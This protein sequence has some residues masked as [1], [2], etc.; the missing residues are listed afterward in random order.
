M[1]NSTGDV[2]AYVMGV[3]PYGDSNAATPNSR[4]AF[5]VWEFSDTTQEYLYCDIFM[6]GW[7]GST[8]IVIKGVCYFGSGASSGEEA[9]VE[10]GWRR[11]DTSEDVDTS[12]SYSVQGTSISVPATSGCPVYWS[13]TFTSAQIDGTLED[14]RARLLIQR[15]VTHA[16]DDAADDMQFDD[17]GFRIEAA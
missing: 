6:H 5:I 16:D 11:I 2:I 7:D 12:H 10:I 17:M 8:N 3:R 15:N 1:P 14:E 13:I 9:R 4:N